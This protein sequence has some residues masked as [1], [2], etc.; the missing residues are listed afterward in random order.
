MITRLLTTKFKKK[1]Y[2]NNA[3]NE[4]LRVFDI[5]IMVLLSKDQFFKNFTRKIT[6]CIKSRLLDMVIKTRNTVFLQMRQK[7]IRVGTCTS[8]SDPLALCDGIR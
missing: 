6:P 3:V 7:I 4:I 8:L 5:I 2:K 1:N